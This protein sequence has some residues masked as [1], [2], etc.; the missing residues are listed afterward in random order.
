MGIV[1][2]SLLQVKNTVKNGQKDRRTVIR[3]ISNVDN[4]RVIG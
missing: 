1:V 3:I 2:S 4:T